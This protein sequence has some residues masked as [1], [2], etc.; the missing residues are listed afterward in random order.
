[1]H[2]PPPH[3]KTLTQKDT[4]LL[5][6]GSL[7]RGNSISVTA[8]ARKLP[9]SIVQSIA[10]ANGYPDLRKLTAASQAARGL[11]HPQPD[12]PRSIRVASGMLPSDEA[13]EWLEQLF[14]LGWTATQVTL[15]TG[16]ERSS[17]S[18][19]R[20]GQDSISWRQHELIKEFM[21]NPLSESPPPPLDELEKIL[22][23]VD[24][25]AARNELLRLKNEGWSTA[26]MAHSLRMHATS[27]AAIINGKTGKIPKST[28]DRILSLESQERVVTC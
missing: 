23:I 13:Q 22:E 19:L 18:R 9:V 14:L 20:R 11:K 5:V 24:T 6:L 21:Q 15:A 7:A 25:A 2:Y 3:Q 8:R 1:M 27:V 12:A 17:V 16:V 10:Y 28:E 26:R 4:E